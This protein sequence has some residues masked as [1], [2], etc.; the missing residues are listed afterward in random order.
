MRVVHLYL[1]VR[2]LVLLPLD[3]P[4]TIVPD[5][6]PPPT[7]SARAYTYMRRRREGGFA[8]ALQS[9]FSVEL[10]G[11][12]KCQ[13]AAE[14]F[15][16]EVGLLFIFIPFLYFF[17]SLSRSMAE[18]NTYASTTSLCVRSTLDLPP[19]MPIGRAKRFW[20][21]IPRH[22]PRPFRT[23][24]HPRQTHSMGQP[25]SSAVEGVIAETEGLLDGGVAVGA[26]LSDLCHDVAAS[27]E[28]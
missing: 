7:L 16:L 19:S 15:L 6:V 11:D 24:T 14:E 22:P 18:C 10:T 5:V 2:L 25:F 17:L 20:S 9:V 13:A 3:T 23:H 8:G 26:T 12:K 21:I 27:R 1:L 4:R 28:N